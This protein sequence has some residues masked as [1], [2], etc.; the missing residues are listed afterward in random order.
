MYPLPA[1][2]VL[3]SASPRGQEDL[4]VFCDRVPIQVRFSRD[5]RDAQSSGVV[6]DD[7]P[8]LREMVCLAPAHIKS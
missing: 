7:R 3:S 6:P 2:I 1:P 5:F 8:D 4:E